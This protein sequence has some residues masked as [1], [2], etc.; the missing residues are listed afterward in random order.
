M[1]KFKWII[2]KFCQFISEESGMAE[3]KWMT[4]VVVVIF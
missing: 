3:L 2:N 1:T 4:E